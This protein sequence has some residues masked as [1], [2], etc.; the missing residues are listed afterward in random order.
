M[1]KQIIEHLSRFATKER[2]NNFLKVIAQRTKYI[3][4][5]IEDVYQSHNASAVLRS[6]DCFGVQDVNIIENLNRYEINPQVALGSYKWLSINNF[7]QEN[8]NNTKVAIDTLRNQ[9][10]RIVATTPHENDTNL[11]DFNLE[12]GKFALLFGTELTGLSPLALENSDEFLKIPMFGFTES[13]NISVSAAIILQ[14]LTD[15]IRKS[16]I[17][18]NLTEHESDL[19]MID[20]LK[21]SVNNSDLIIERFIKN[22]R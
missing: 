5:I 18:W 1:E 10:Y 11:D 15:K 16:N 7:N 2:V 22:K 19:V 9:G 4:V 14:N 6:C 17:N 12:K 8:V 13:L 3:A 21:K 20:W